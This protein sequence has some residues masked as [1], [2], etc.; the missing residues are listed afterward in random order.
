MDTSGPMEKRGL[1]LLKLLFPAA[2]RTANPAYAE[3]FPVP[4]E[5][6]KAEAIGYQNEAIAKWTG[7]WS[8]L[9]SISCPTLFVTGAD[10]LLTPPRNAEMMAAIVPGAELVQIPGAGHGLMYQEPQKLAGMVTDFL[11]R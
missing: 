3:D 4:S 10:D 1:R 5:P 6:M 8:S 9:T 11:D 7:V 2:Y